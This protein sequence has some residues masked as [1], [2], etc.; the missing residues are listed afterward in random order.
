MK[1]DFN[2]IQENL[3]QLSVVNLEEQLSKRA[4]VA[5]ILSNMDEN[6]DVQT[7]Y[8]NQK[9][10]SI[11]LIKRSTHPKDPWSGQWALPGGKQDPDDKN[12]FH[13][14]TREVYEEIGLRLDSHQMLGFLSDLQARRHG[15]PVDFF[16]RPLV[17]YSGSA[18]TCDFVL[19][20]EEVAQAK[21]FPLQ[22]LLEPHRHHV[23]ERSYQG[24]S[25]QLP[26]IHLGPNEVLW[27]LTYIILTDFLQSQNLLPEYWKKYT[28][29]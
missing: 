3:N 6:V 21:W 24:R 14:A 27:G 22:S 23:F 12:D 28:R 4:C 29:I 25:F 19:N 20:T 11:L 26:G 13:T 7:E 1:L 9:V 5:L 17:F 15:D 8:K 2:L 10:D 16:V 18:L